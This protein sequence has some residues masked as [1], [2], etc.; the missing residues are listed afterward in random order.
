MHPYRE[1]SRTTY[2]SHREPM[3]T[4]QLWDFDGDAWAVVATVTTTP[5]CAIYVRRAWYH[6]AT[7]STCLSLADEPRLQLSMDSASL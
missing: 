4:L 2:P 7:L 3:Y 5:G 1:W 6:G